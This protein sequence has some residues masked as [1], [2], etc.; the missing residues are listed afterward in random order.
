MGRDRFLRRLARSVLTS[1]TGE[2]RQVQAHF[3]QF[4]R[5]ELDPFQ[6]PQLGETR[7]DDGAF[8]R[9]LDAAI[10]RRAPQVPPVQDRRQPSVAPTR[11]VAKGAS[12]PAPAAP[13]PNA[14]QTASAEPTRL[15]PAVATEDHACAAETD[16]Y[17]GREAANRARSPAVA[18]TPAQTEPA[19]IADASPAAVTAPTAPPTPAVHAPVA[20]PVVTAASG[21]GVSTSTSS[22]LTSLA[23]GEGRI[24]RTSSTAATVGYRSVEKPALDRVEAARESVLRQIV[25]KLQDGSSEARMHLEPPELGTLDLR[26]AVDASGG[27]SLSVVADRPDIAALL[28]SSLPQLQS[29]LANQG[30]TI[31]QAEVKSRDG[32]TRGDSVPASTARGARGARSIA[33]A[34]DDTPASLAFV[35]TTGLDFWA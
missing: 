2:S 5:V 29:S 13:T 25:F 12:D 11:Q 20:A 18:G 16:T 6:I 28:A 21:S 34:A 31:T 8:A 23:Q 35:S 14:R 4:G 30:L 7:R 1:S 26:L 22:G 27:T 3:T 10:D 19:A 33:D 32:K 24:A 9:Q 15:A 17:L